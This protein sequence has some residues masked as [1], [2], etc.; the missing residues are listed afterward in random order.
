MPSCV[1]PLPRRRPPTS[2]PRAPRYGA[3]SQPGCRVPGPVGVSLRA[4]DEGSTGLHIPGCSST[5]C[6]PRV[7]QGAVH[8][9]TQRSSLTRS[10]SE[11]CSKL[12]TSPSSVPG[13]GRVACTR[14]SLAERLHCSGAATC[15]GGEGGRDVIC[16]TRPCWGILRKQTPCL[17]NATCL[18]PLGLHVPITSRMEAVR[19]CKRDSV[20]SGAASAGVAAVCV[21]APAL[22]HTEPA[23]ESELY[24]DWNLELVLQKEA[25]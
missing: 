23:R 24:T 3:S 15:M 16:T 9:V 20:F 12:R 5:V 8:D 25:V 14:G 13:Y 21:E 10:C 19:S 18:P 6:H 2:L 11:T 1:D 22:L 17:S 7:K 4:P